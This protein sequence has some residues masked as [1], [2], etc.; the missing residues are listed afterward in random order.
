MTRAIYIEIQ[1]S[2]AVIQRTGSIF[3][4]HTPRINLAIYNSEICLFVCQARRIWRESER[5]REREYTHVIDLIP[6]YCI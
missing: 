6:D 2:Y 3:N 4:F 5:E 1:S